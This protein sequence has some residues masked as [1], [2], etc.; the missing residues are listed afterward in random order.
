MGVLCNQSLTPT[1]T[2]AVP[3]Q[4]SEPRMNY[5]TRLLPADEWH[6]LHGT[7]L[8]KVYPLLPPSAFIIVVEN[9]QGSI[10]GCWSTYAV[11]HAECVWI[12]PEHQKKGAVARRLWT[13]M[14][15]IATDLNTKAAW[16]TVTSPALDHLLASRA[17]KVP[18]ES[19]VLNLV[20]E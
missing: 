13:A 19:Y 10:V 12:D 5:T 16:V 11:M 18:G 4:H 15:Q 8:E 17:T 9:E 14:Q 6:R 7:E 2:L 1:L 3:I 20:K